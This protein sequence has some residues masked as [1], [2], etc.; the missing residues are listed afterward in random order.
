MIFCRCQHLANGG[1]RVSPTLTIIARRAFLPILVAASFQCGSTVLATGGAEVVVGSD[2]RG[3]ER[4]IGARDDL[5]RL[6]ADWSD[7]VARRGGD[8]VRKVLGTVYA[9][10]KCEASLCA[11]NLFIDKFVRSPDAEFD[12]SEFDSKSLQLQQAI[13]SADFLAYASVFADYGNGGGSGG[14]KELLED[15]RKQVQVAIAALDDLIKVVS[16]K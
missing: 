10:P 1:P 13:S 4:F 3:V 2:L 11:W 12:L 5:R 8:G 7:V 16:A 14:S 6:D 15:A 9:P